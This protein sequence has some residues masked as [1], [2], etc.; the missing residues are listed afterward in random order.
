M[1]GVCL[2][3]FAAPLIRCFLGVVPGSLQPRQESVAS[4]LLCLIAELGPKKQG[5][6][7]HPRQNHILFSPMNVA[8]MNES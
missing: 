2:L 5:C 8:D 7:A 3:G 1:K 4:A 6:P